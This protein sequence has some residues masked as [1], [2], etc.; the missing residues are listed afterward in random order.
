MKALRYFL[1][2][3]TVFIALAAGVVSAETV[4]I[5]FIDP[6]SGLMGSLVQHPVNGLNN[7]LPR[8]S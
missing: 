3:A 1:T 6:L 8:L 2:G 5:A 4:K 7:K